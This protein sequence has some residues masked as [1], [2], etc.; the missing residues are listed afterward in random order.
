MAYV[1]ISDYKKQQQVRLWILASFLFDKECFKYI[2]AR[3]V[4]SNVNYTKYVWYTVNDK[5]KLFNSP[6]SIC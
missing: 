1:R 4:Y 6:L 3:L 2:C 5:K